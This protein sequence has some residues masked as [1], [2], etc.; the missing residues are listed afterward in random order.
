MAVEIIKANIAHLKALLEAEAD[1]KKR[2]P[3]ERQLA[4]QETRLAT[5]LKAP[6]E[7]QGD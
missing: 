2:A 6:G 5:L 4:E 1:P 7:R 3:L